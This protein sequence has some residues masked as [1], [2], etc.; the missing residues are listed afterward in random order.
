MKK[1]ITE[2]Q[3]LEWVYWFT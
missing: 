2:F 3:T 1:Y